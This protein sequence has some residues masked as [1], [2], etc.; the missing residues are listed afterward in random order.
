MVLASVAFHSAG[1]TGGQRVLLDPYSKVHKWYHLDWTSVSTEG[2]V[3][4]SLRPA[5]ILPVVG[6]LL[7]YA[8]NSDPS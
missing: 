1:G 6:V 7:G 3:S 2:T 5:N 4:G 8:V